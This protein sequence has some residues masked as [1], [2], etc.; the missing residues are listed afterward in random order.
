MYGGFSL[1]LKLLRDRDK[2]ASALGHGL[3]DLEPII[4]AK[5]VDAILRSL[6]P[7]KGRQDV[8]L[9]SD[10]QQI[11][12]SEANLAERQTLLDEFDRQT[13]KREAKRAQKRAEELRQERF[14]AWV[15]EH[16]DDPPCEPPA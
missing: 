13:R 15:R 6:G 1:R 7:G 14:D 11:T 8:L 10:A 9:A 5:L 4:R 3:L 16:G 2:A 12:L